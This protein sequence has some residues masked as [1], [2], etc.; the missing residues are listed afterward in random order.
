MVCSL[1]GRDTALM[2]TTHPTGLKVFVAEDSALMREAIGN[3]LTAAGFVVVGC[4]ATPKDCVAGVRRASPDVLVLDGQLEG[5][6]GLSVLRALKPLAGLVVIVFTNRASP[7]FRK[8][9]LEEGAHA[10]LDK[11]AD[12]GQLAPTARHVWRV[13]H[14]LR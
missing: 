6:T 14:G 1:R 12:F 10:V 8:R 5:G 11:N 7:V 9:Y 13:T 4:G 3:L 2:N